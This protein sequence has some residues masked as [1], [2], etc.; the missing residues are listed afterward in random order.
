MS[1][2]PVLERVL[3]RL[4]L[5]LF[6]LCAVLTI[7]TLASAA[8]IGPAWFAWWGLVVV[9]FFLPYGL[10]TAELG[11]AWPDEGGPFVWVR[12]GLGPRWG[13]LAAWFY[14]VNVAYWTPSVALVFASTFDSIFL[15]PHLPVAFRQGPGQAWLEC[16]LALVVTWLTV[17]FG[18][19]RLRVSKWVPNLGA[20]VKVA[21]FAGLGL[22]GVAGVLAGQ[23]PA[24]DLAPARFLPRLS[25][26]LAFLPVVLYNGLG[27]ELMSAAGGEMRAPQRDVPRAILLSGALITALY[28]LGALGILLAV[29]LSELSL[30]TGTWDA[31]QALARPWGAAAGWL[32][33]LLGLG[34]LYACL[35]NVV[36]WSLGANRVIA[37]A[38]LDGL[39]PEFFGR[40]H[41]VRGTP[42]SAFLAMGLLGSALLVGNAL[43]SDSAV[44]VF[45]LTFKLA[46]LCFLVPYL[47]V[48]PAFL[49]LRLTE[50]GRPR[51]YRLPGGPLAAGAACLSSFL[52]VAA[53]GVL[54]FAPTPGSADPWGEFAWLAGQTLLTLLVGLLLVPRPPRAAS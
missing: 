3:G 48:F 45:W 2:T 47:L 11:A 4:D 19:L 32:A 41:P 5:L 13:A 35:A 37:A 7:D 18:L 33:W 50:P 44:N 9:F 49:R 40:L 26:S 53:A 10:V 6:S 25:D 12:A 51:P 23:P 54:F 24:N 52:C 30:L 38:A 39:A 22:L 17:L 28:A 8:S 1:A 46:S 16:G 15:R 36:A 42:Q 27:F 20:V 34:F 43:F 21:L 31:L 14:W 29:P